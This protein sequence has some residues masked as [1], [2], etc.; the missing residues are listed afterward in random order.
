MLKLVHYAPVREL[1]RGDILKAK[2]ES[3]KLR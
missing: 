3:Q 1:L 2:Q